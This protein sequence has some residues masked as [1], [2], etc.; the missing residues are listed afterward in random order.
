MKLLLPSE[1]QHGCLSLSAPFVRP[2]NI[3]FRR[4]WVCQVRMNYHVFYRKLSKLDMVLHV[5]RSM[6]LNFDIWFF[7]VALDLLSLLAKLE[8][9]FLLHQRHVSSLLFGS[10]IPEN[11]WV[12]RLQ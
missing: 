11:N 3:K 6:A 1:N 4:R 2:E 12:A 8:T 9:N 7:R 10:V 5:F